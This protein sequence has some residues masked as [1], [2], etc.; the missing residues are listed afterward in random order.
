MISSFH[1]VQ[2]ARNERFF[3][4]P[5]KFDLERVNDENKKS[6]LNSIIIPFSLG[7]RM[8]IGNRYALI[9]LKLITY[10]LLSNFKIYENS[11]TPHH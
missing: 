10:K 11:K 8:C 4:N 6:I 9:E 5:E 7:P 3:T 1:L 2:C